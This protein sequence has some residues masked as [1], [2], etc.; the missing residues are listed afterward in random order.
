MTKQMPT[1]VIT[2]ASGFI[3]KSMVTYFVGQ[4]WHVR[5][6][7]RNPNAHADTPY[8]TY[9]AYDLE[10]SPPAAAF[11]GADYVLHAAYIKTDKKHPDAHRTNILGTRQ[12]LKASRASGIQ[13]TVFL[14]SMSAQADALSDYGKQKFE[15]ERDFT[16]Q[17]D[18]V[19]RPGLVIGNGGLVQ[20]IVNVMQ[21]LHVV[22]IIGG[23][24]QPLQ[25]VALYDLQ[26]A[27]AH[28]FTQDIY[29]TF[30]VAT[31][32][33]YTYREFYNTL[34][35]KLHIK[36]W[37]MPVPFGLVL[38]GIRFARQLRLPLRITEDNLQ[39]IKKLRSQETLQDLRTLGIQLDPL[40]TILSKLDL[41]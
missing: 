13:K 4:K 28:S 33:V 24:N 1:V 7:V 32:E 18:V 23:G 41:P 8:V 39:G 37:L 35:R 20:N 30:T 5:A 17:H 25:V 19:L 9:F 11:A 14:S 3:G 22:P 12:L 38:F 29:G 40:E 6:L 27:I 2:G 31:P 26:K 16:G 10:S 21:R 34:R 36:A 15:L